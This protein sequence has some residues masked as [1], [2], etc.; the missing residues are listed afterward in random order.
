MQ[1]I[2][3]VRPLVDDVV[4]VLNTELTVA[5]LAEDITEIGYP[6]EY[7]GACRLPQIRSGLC[8]A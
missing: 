1:G 3:A 4:R 7:A 5:D 2:C 8:P 6:T